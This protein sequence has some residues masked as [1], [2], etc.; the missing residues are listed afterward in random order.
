MKT[1]AAVLHEV[2]Q[3][4]SVEEI[5]LDPPK[6]G[7]VLV[8]TAY[9][10]LCHS[11]EHLVTGDL[12]PP[13]DMMEMMGITEYLPMIGGH[14]GSGIVEEVGPGVRSLKPGDHVSVSFIPSCGHC[15]WCASG[16]Q[17]LCDLGAML[18]LGG[19][20]TDSTYRH[21]TAKGQTLRTMCKLGTFSEHLVVSEDSLI[22]VDPDLPLAAVALVS[23]GVATGWGSAVHRAGVKAGETV[24]II[25][26]GGIGI[27][28]V[29]GA[30]MAG[31][32][33]I[34]AID[35]LEFKREKAQEFGATHSAP[36]AAEA[37]PLVQELTQG[38]M[39]DRVICTPG[40]MTGDILAPALSLVRKGGSVVVTAV[41]PMAQSQADINLF[42]LTCSNKEVK[43]AIFGSL[44][45][46][47]DIPLLLSYYQQGSLKLD[48]LIT[49]EYPLEG[50]NQG[51]QDM[52]D[53]KNIR[54]VLN[55]N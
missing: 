14:E 39:A 8:K 55:L 48:E 24:A 27:N 18:F 34:I 21:H 15:R 26:I 19:M 31:A 22:K 43:G 30:R 42:D 17:N 20:I 46:R 4:W 32:G 49:Q 29:Q 23:C 10:G 7:E 16:M 40:V 41:A 38:V 11:D 50:I 35:P 1:R 51:Y 3:D 28:A 12:V 54:G 6:E 2:G 44:N 52:R 33:K 5:Q 53:G 47:A 25:G 45:P 9:A 36:S 37:F 13:P